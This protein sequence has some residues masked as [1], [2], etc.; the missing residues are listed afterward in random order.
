MEV[1]KGK[2]II[3]VTLLS[4]FFGGLWGAFLEIL[5]ERTGDHLTPQLLNIGAMAIVGLYAIIKMQDKVSALESE[6]KRL[7]ADLRNHRAL[8]IMQELTTPEAPE[9]QTASRAQGL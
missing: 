5:A 8:S 2:T 6:N 4:G 7:R 9:A 3:R 1:S